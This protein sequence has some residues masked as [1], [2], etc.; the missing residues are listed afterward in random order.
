MKYKI[1]IKQSQADI[2]KAF[3]DPFIKDY[4]VT[5]GKEIS[6]TDL[7]EG[8]SYYKHIT[9]SKRKDKLTTIVLNKYSYPNYYRFSLK[10]SDCFK[11][12]GFIVEPQDGYCDV[13]IESYYEQL[14]DGESSNNFEH[15]L[16]DEPLC[17]P[18]FLTQPRME[19]YVKKFIKKQAQN[20]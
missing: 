3:V 11:V 7:N 2:F 20:S 16:D 18:G 13:T 10:N 15:G 12:S 17:T 5:S 4:Y 6:F 14:K 8:F 9:Q 1:K 19:K